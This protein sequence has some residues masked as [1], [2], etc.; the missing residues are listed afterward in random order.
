M[1]S[2]RR[3]HVESPRKKKQR[4]SETAERFELLSTSDIK[5]VTLGTPLCCMM[6]V[7]ELSIRYNGRS[8]LYESH[9]SSRRTRLQSGV[10]VCALS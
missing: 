3:V 1:S 6:C 10:H 4:A 9:I 8:A 5:A 2:Y 7:A